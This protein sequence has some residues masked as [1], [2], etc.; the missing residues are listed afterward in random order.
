MADLAI[1]SLFDDDDP[2]SGPVTTS[3]GRRLVFF[4]FPDTSWDVTTTHHPNRFQE[5]PG[6]DPVKSWTRTTCINVGTPHGG[7]LLA[8]G[9][10]KDIKDSLYIMG[11]CTAGSTK[12]YSLDRKFDVEA[13]WIVTM[14]DTY[15]SKEFPG[16]IKVYACHSATGGANKESPFAKLFA[17]AMRKAGYT[18][19]SFFGY[20][21]QVSGFASKT[22]K[23]DS[24]VTDNSGQHRWTLDGDNA[25]KRARISQI[26]IV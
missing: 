20:N 13:D 8:L 17:D 11:Q 10:L 23:G 12:L 7:K 14:L 2:F 15:L 3:K 9:T 25:G 1:P 18:R 5:K 6:E 26:P 24:N 19:C 22:Y 4:P 21:A 16:K